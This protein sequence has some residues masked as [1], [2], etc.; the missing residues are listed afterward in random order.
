[1]C[2]FFCSPVPPTPKLAERPDTKKERRFSRRSCEYGAD[3]LLL[4]NGLVGAQDCEVG[5][6]GHCDTLEEGFFAHLQ[7]ID[8]LGVRTLGHGATAGYPVGFILGNAVHAIIRVGQITRA[9]E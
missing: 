6:L 8:E 3:Q 9:I 4:P 2:G 5:P 1:M 7:L